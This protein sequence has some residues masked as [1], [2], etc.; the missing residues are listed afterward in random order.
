MKK[1]S[2]KTAATG[3]VVFFIT[4]LL[5]QCKKKGDLA[6]QLD[7]GLKS[8]PDS[9]VYAPFYDTTYI[10]VRDVVPD[11]NDLIK[12]RGVINIIK[13]YCATSNCHGTGSS[14]NPK[15]LTYTDI[16]R[17]V[18]PGVP[19]SSK[20]WEYVTTNDF[21]KAM[22]PVN[23][24]KELSL[25]D[26]TIIYNW[27]MNG[28]KERPALT[29]FRQ[30]AIRI[31]VD[32]C[33]SAN[34]HSQG[35]ATGQWARAGLLS[36]ITPADT[37]TFVAYTGRSYSILTNLTKRNAVWTAYKDSVKKF[38]GGT[39]L[40]D[41]AAV[42]R[43]SFRPYKTFSSPVVGPSGSGINSP[44]TR[45]PLNSYDD[46][47]MDIMYPKSLR[48]SGSVVYNVNGQNFYVR[49]NYLN[50]AN[51]NFLHRIDSTLHTANPFTGVY[52]TSKGGNMAYQDGGLSPSEI[53]LIKAWYFADP[54]IP[55]VWKYGQNNAGMFR[56][57]N[58]GTVIRK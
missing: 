17:Y 14:I 50:I 47:L 8:I 16:M 36:G 45:G 33:G 30:A 1:L 25:T 29:D 46:I 38:Y 2:I 26:K 27:I 15:L 23:S 58:S 31:I 43:V 11:V 41:T 21:D 20:L 22:P 19:S 48:S 3:I 53:A 13:E 57:K 37:T 56:Y 7:R 49:G 6:R 55:E 51:G 18:T 44:N 10:D 24:N 4:A 12:K 5:V 39:T 35:T 34:C 32:G 28:A 52:S 54:N 9:T 40:A 42:D